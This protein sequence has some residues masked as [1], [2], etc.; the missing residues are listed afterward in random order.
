MLDHKGML[1][2]ISLLFVTAPALA[3]VGE[4]PEQGQG[5]Q[6]AQGAATDNAA[7]DGAAE[8]T[9]EQQYELQ[10]AALEQSLHFQQGKVGL[11]DDLAQL[12]LGQDL[13]YLDAADTEKVLVAWGNPP[14]SET[15][16]MLMP[17]SL[18]PFA[19]EGWGVIVTYEEEGHVDDEDAEDLDYDEM[20]AGMQKQTEDDNPERQKAGYPPVH[21][22]GWAEP[23]HY[24]GAHKKL[25]WAKELDFGGEQHTLNYAVRVLGRKGVLELN[26]VAAMP[27]LTMIRGAMASVI[28]RVEFEQ[29]NRYADFDPEL[30]ELAAYG[31]GALIAGKVAAKAGLFKGLVALLLASKKLLVA[32]G[33]AVLAALR[34]LFSGKK[35]QS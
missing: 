29:G 16:G 22:I 20:L 30:D 7:D 14:G 28:E 25:Y 31:V 35:A 18:S 5:A 1:A 6:D 11:G 12:E 15:L 13:R 27:Q 34:A 32:G 4:L 21:L 26:A 19:D 2:A 33:V 24:D 8:L 9:E 23:P 3:D 17:A 10:L